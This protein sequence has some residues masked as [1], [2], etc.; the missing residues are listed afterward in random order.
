MSHRC[1]GQALVETALL[2]AVFAGLVA[3]L[4]LTLMLH[5]VQR[6]ALRN[7]RDAVQLADWDRGRTSRAEWLAPLR[8]TVEAL[9]WRQPG[10]GARVVP[11]PDDEALEVA[12][13]APPGHAA[14]MLAFISAPLR[15]GG[16]EDSRFDLSS[17][18]LREA[19]VTLRVPPV[20]G[21]VEP[22]DRLD[23]DFSQRVASLTDA[24]NAGGS[25]QV[26]ERVSG[27]VPTAQLRSL[28]APV[29]AVAALVSFIEPALR[30]L[31]IGHIDAEQLPQRRLERA[32]ARGVP[33]VSA[34]ECR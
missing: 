22:F 2:A 32:A 19:T 23:L 1:N 20:L 14:R 6:T 5:D 33:R 28:V 15:A 27:L 17:L 21:A 29:E 4:P 8:A 13:S 10:D 3:A 31:C 9:P 16:F 18:G 12:D 7:A 30:D 24:W 11:P 25:A 34:T 26:R